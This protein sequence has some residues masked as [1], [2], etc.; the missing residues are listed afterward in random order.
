MF[1]MKRVLW[2]FLFRE[3]QQLQM[4]QDRLSRLVLYSRLVQ[5]RSLRHD[6]TAPLFVASRCQDLRRVFVA[7]LLSFVQRSSTPFKGL[8]AC[9]LHLDADDRLFAERLDSKDTPITRAHSLGTI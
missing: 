2:N 4:A 3:S 1:G 5:E 6:G 9:S 7:T 8:R